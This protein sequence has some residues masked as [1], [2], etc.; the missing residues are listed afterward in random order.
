VLY[1]LFEQR[2][3]QLGAWLKRELRPAT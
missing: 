3:R 2:Y 1:V